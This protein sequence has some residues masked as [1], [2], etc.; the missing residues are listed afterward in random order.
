M[1]LRALGLIAGIALLS[2]CSHSAASTK[3]PRMIVLGV[4]GMDPGFV[5]QHWDVLPNLDKLRQEGGFSRLATTTPPQSPVAWSAVITGMDPGGH[6][7]FDFLHRDPQTITPYSS[8]AEATGG[9]RSLAIGPWVLPLQSGTVKSLR[10]GTAFWEVLAQRGVPTAILRMP[11]NFPPVDYPGDSLAGMGTPDLRGD[12]GNFTYFTS[13]PSVKP[14]DVSGGR[15]VPVKLENGRA[16]L[17]V[18][19]P[20]NPLLRTHP[21]TFVDLVADVDAGTHAARFTAGSTQVVL[22][23]GE[24]SPWIRV[25][26]PLL[27]EARTIP[28]M[29]RLLLRGAGP[30]LAVYVSPVN[31]DPLA[32]ALPLSTPA[33][34][35]KTLAEAIGPFYTQGIAEDTSAVRAEVLSHAQF[36]QQANLVLDDNLAMYRYELDHYRDGLLFYY[37]SSVDQQSHILWGDRDDEL[38]PVYRKIDE[39]VG[40]ARRKLGSDGTLIVMSDH[41]FSTFRRAVHL[42]TWLMKEGFLKL[43]DPNRAG[44]EELF[45]NVDWAQTQA[46]ALGLNEIYLN[47]AGREPNGIVAPGEEARAVLARIQ[48]RLRQFRDPQTGEPVVEQAYT[49]EQIGTSPMP[50]YAPDLVVGYRPGYRASWQTALGAVPAETVVDNKEAW[51]ADHCIDPRFVPGVFFSNRKP[52][53]L[54]PSLRDV[55]VTILKA[56]GAAPPKQ[57]TGTS[58]F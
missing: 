23:E 39:A 10:R 37:F 40:L 16:M 22:R 50:D 53:N 51:L 31:I 36:L 33:D 6:G 44:D 30:N 54:D 14:R 13:D 34:Y 49:A 42:N 25:A 32:P 12:S 41:G 17:R 57:M 11:T 18:D 24:W 48:E 28:G 58:I 55:P 3:S 8:M 26:F 9:G 45:P 21:D 2:A 7:I 27:G 19:G 1:K 5:E 47:L 38:L 29:F 15:I 46:Y 20:V 56:F 4:D 35:S 52:S 43:I